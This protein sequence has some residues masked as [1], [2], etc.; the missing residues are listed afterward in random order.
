M[1]LPFD[2]IQAAIVAT[3]TGNILDLSS[4]AVPVLDDIPQNHPYPYIEIGEYDA[5]F[6]HAKAE[7]TVTDAT[8][9]I[10]VV[11]SYAG[12]REVNTMMAK[13]V[14]AFIFRPMSIGNDFEVLSEGFVDDVSVE[15]G[16][17][18]DEEILR[19]G[20]LEYRWRVADR[21]D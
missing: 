19:R 18:A 12:T 9:I 4:V 7:I 10:R 11:S 20:T 14:D 5:E 17:S 8:Y 6:D 2:D 1:R 16:E 21:L 15:K 3:L 13:I